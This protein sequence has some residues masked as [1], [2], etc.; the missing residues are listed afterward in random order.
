MDTSIDKV[1]YIVVKAREFD[2]QE[3]VVEEDVGSNPADED[4]REVLAAYPDDP[5]YEELKTFIE[6]LNE[7]EQVELVALTWLG[8]GD[9]TA[10]DWNQAVAQ[11]RER[12]KGSTADYLLG[13]PLLPDLLEEGLAALDLSCMG[14]EMGHL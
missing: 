10:G 7:D 11:A 1:C 13:L 5:T 4:F 8:R 6:D 12:H 3:E 2:A 9:F 14:F